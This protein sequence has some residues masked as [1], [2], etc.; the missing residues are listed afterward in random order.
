VEILSE[1]GE[2][3]RHTMYEE[4]SELPFHQ[5]LTSTQPTEGEAIEP[6]RG[7]W[8]VLERKGKG[9]IESGQHGA[10]PHR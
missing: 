3:F 6:P 8:K 2:Q 9:E 4:A 1:A 7:T 5:Y 10:S